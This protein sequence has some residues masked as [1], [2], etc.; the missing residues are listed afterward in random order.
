L[1]IAGFA[2][3]P[4]WANYSASKSYDLFLAEA[5]AEELKPTGVDGRLT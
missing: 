3:I 5:L 1:S 4:F 2:P